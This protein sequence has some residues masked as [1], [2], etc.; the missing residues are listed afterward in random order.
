[1]RA[2]ENTRLSVGLSP[3]RGACNSGML[4]SGEAVCGHAAA[5][6]HASANKSKTRKPMGKVCTLVLDVKLRLLAPAFF[7]VFP[8]FY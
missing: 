2:G 7:C 1:M 3:G 6:L 4:L 8:R 5:G